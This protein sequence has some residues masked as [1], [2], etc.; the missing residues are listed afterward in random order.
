MTILWLSFYDRE[1]SVA[2]H[3][4]VDKQTLFGCGAEFA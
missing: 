1:V 2:C 3:M 4:L